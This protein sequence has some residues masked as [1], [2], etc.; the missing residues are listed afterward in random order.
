MLKP[1]ILEWCREG[2]ALALPK[3]GSQH[4]HPLDST[5]CVLWE[6]SMPCPQKAAVV[7][8]LGG[9]GF[10]VVVQCDGWGAC[11]G[12]SLL[13]SGVMGC[14]LSRAAGSS[15]AGS[16]INSPSGCRAEMERTL[17]PCAHCYSRLTLPPELMATPS[18]L[19]R[20]PYIPL[21]WQKV[22]QCCGTPRCGAVGLVGGSSVPK[23]LGSFGMDL[24]WEQGFGQGGIPR[25]EAAACRVSLMISNEQLP[26]VSPLISEYQ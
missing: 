2:R 12:P 6:A 16:Y 7:T 25:R 1:L 10:A 5:P 11:G 26:L 13:G 18:S 14:R 24:F 20:L 17:W 23:S 9:L 3:E 21:T 4:P 22:G 8:R 19:K 15:R